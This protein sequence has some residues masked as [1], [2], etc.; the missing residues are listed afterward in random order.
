MSNDSRKFYPVTIHQ[1]PGSNGLYSTVSNDWIVCF[2]GTA[3][4]F[5]CDRVLAEFVFEAISARQEGAGE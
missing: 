3:I 4:N 1:M 2:G 5:G